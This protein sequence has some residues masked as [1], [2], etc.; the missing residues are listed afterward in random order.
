VL[1]GPTATIPLAD[2]KRRRDPGFRA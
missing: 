2:V 1:G